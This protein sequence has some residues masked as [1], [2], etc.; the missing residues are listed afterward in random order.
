MKK[1]KNRIFKNMFIMAILI[2]VSSILLT[3]AIMYQHLSKQNVT[4]LKNELKSISNGV[5]IVGSNYLRTLKP[6]HRITLIDKKGNVIY[7]SE[8]DASSMENHSD[9]EEISEALKD[10]EGYSE[11]YSKTLSKKTVNVAGRLNDGT[12]LRV[13]DTSDTVWFI[14]IDILLP[15]FIVLAAAIVM[16]GF[17]ALRISKIIT[18]PINE[19]D[20]SNPDKTKSYEEIS[21]LLDKINEQNRQI[22]RQMEELNMEHE[23]QDHMR[24][25]FTANVSH[26]LKTPL[27]SISGFAEIIQN[28]IVKEEDIRR[29]AG[30][31]HDESQR[32]ITLVGDIIKLSQLDGRDIAVKM[33]PIDLYETSQV[34]MS[35]LEAAAEK[36][37]V[38]MRLLGNRIVIM[39]AEQ[40]VE[41]MIF[42]LVDNAIKYNKDGGTVTVEICRSD[43]GIE[44]SVADTGIGIPEEDIDRIFE[45]FFR[46]DKS[47]SKNIGGTGLGLS[48]VKHGAIFH[49]ARLSVKS[50][51]NV[52][53][54]I[55]ITF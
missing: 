43:K 40:I 49:N 48:I 7:D 1:M 44:L 39:G 21:P 9:R 50:K 54:E 30:K 51:L 35:H 42:N 24:R 46:V 47:H 18:K 29:F 12:V 13:S 16:A 31:I 8:T 19:I 10:G 36:R 33:E 38:T 20:L 22:C 23:K 32:L 15:M 41:E 26:E 6:G 34:V 17:L 11:R 28:G 25:D 3:V 4:A 37:E 53:T 45:R 2:L 52:G 5:N 27:T 55:K 14:M